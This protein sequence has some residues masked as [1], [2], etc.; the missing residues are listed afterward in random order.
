MK[1][2]LKEL[3]ERKQLTQ[4]QVGRELGITQGRISM[5]EHG[6]R[7]LSLRDGIKLAE[8]YDVNVRDLVKDND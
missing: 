2:K 6:K 8:L 5:L 7:G 3:R 1:S 4:E